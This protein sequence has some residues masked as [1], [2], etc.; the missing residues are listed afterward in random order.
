MLTLAAYSAEACVSP[1]SG[2]ESSFP[3]VAADTVAGVS[4]VSLRFWPV[5]R[6][7]L[8]TVKVPG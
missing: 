1:S 5:R 3:N 8:W 4:A 7:S 2:Y 6:L